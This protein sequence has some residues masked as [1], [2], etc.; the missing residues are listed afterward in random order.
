MG[1]RRRISFPGS[2]GATEEEEEDEEDEGPA[3]EDA[4]EGRVSMGSERSAK[5]GYT[6]CSS[7]FFSSACRD[8]IEEISADQS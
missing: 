8:S 2:G 1:G 6:V 5:T 7:A 3:V 4:S